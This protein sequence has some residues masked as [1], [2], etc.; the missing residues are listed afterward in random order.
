M[1]QRKPIPKRTAVR[2]PGPTTAVVTD[3]HPPH[4]PEA[5]RGLLGCLFRAST[6]GSQAQ[7]DAII[8]GTR[9]GLFFDLRLRNAWLAARDI[10]SAGHALD[11]ITFLQW[12][13][14]KGADFMAHGDA[15]QVTVMQD[16][17]PSVLMWTT[18]RDI[19]TDKARRRNI[20]SIA[21]KAR[22]LAG[23]STLDPADLRREFALTLDDVARA[24]ANTRPRLVIR[25]A[26]ERR[27]YQPPPGIDLVGTAEIFKGNEGFSVIAGPGSSGKSLLVGT[28][29]LAGA[30]GSGT[31]M[32]RKVHRKFRTLVIQ[33]E[34]GPMRLKRQME[35]FQKNHPDADLEGSIF[36]CDPPEGGFAIADTEFWT[37]L[38]RKVEELKPDLV[39][40]DPISHL[41]VEDQGSEVMNAIRIIRQAVGVGDDSPAI[42]FVAHTKKPRS[43]EAMRGRN[44]ANIVS[45][46]V[47]WVNTSRC[48]YLCVPFDAEDIEDDRVYFAA[49]KI[50]DGP[51]Y[52]PTVWRR[53]FGT[54][55]AH[56]PE[57]DP[58][59]WGRDKTK[60]E[61]AAEKHKIRFDDLKKAFGGRPGMKRAELVKALIALGHDEATSYRATRKDGY[62]S[63][64]LVEVAGVMALRSP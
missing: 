8:A 15:V 13:K 32:G 14:D 63:Q 20:L 45:G 12:V 56:D 35:E 19:L 31:W 38:K 30:I 55:F 53:K 43:E 37:E 23:D 10:R 18:Y 6:D 21:A 62:L 39:V 61:V 52:A 7:V 1:T 11:T 34:V 36:Y 22:E 51:N 58:A 4:A 24:D 44:M 25:K 64:Y 48:T 26:S 16:E 47:V 60:D 41:S 59:S 2:R 50:N 40:F 42:L 9:A 29:A 33:G 28:L 49:P 46:S 57:T 3:Q 5:E 17:V 27:A 54:F